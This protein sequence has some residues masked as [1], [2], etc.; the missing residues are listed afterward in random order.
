LLRLRCCAHRYSAQSPE[1]EGLARQVQ[2]RI[3]M[4]AK[5]DDG[6][7]RKKSQLLIMDRGEDMAAPLVHELSYVS[8]CARFT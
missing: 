3:D 8:T 1:C 7:T 6:M 5:F 2:E 4:L